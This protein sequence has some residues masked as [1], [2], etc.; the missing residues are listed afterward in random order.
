MR[1]RIL[2]A[3]GAL[4]AMSAVW[5]IAES[6]LK[7]VKEVARA[8]LSFQPQNLSI[9]DVFTDEVLDENTETIEHDFRRDGIE[10]GFSENA[11]LDL[12]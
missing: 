12:L 11:T 1:E 3:T 10:G 4:K 7:Q 5:A 8:V 9:L 6:V 2:L